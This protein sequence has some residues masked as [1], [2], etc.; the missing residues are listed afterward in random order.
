MSRPQRRSFH[1]RVCAQIA[2]PS[3]HT[4]THSH[5]HARAC[6]AAVIYQLAASHACMSLHA[7]D[8]P[9]TPCVSRI[10]VTSTHASMSRHACHACMHDLTPRMSRILRAGSEVARMRRELDE[11]QPVRV[12][13]A[14]AQLP[15]CRM[16]AEIGRGSASLRSAVSMGR[17]YGSDVFT[18]LVYIMRLALSMQ[19]G[20]I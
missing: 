13:R 16:A 20:V 18:H 11:R 2:R 1:A 7:H 17:V 6:I 9:R 4:R 12:A 14:H 10:S 3:V 8:T 19:S 15:Y 5:L